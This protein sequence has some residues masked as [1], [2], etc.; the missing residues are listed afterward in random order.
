MGKKTVFDR[1]ITIILLGICIV[2]AAIVIKN[3]LTTQNTQ[4]NLPFSAV[5]QTTN[6][7]N[8]S[9]KK[10][11]PEAFVRTTTLGAELESS[12]DTIALTSSTV[13]GKL[14]ALYVTTGKEIKAGD[15]IGIVDPSTAGSV[16]KPSDIKSALSGTVYSVDSYVGA[17]ITTTTT[18]ATL[19]KTGD[20]EVVANLPER[21]LSTVTVGMKATFT[22]AAWP[23]EPFEATVKSISPAVNNSNR[24]FELI[25]SIDQAD[26]RLKEGMYVDLKLITEQ[27]DDCLIIPTSAI[28]T[29]LGENIVF[30]VEDGK[31]K[32]V[33]ITISQEDDNRSVVASGLV[34]SDQ[35]IVAGSVTH[36]SSVNIIEE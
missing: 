21:F 4:G 10:M 9:V 1:I 23:E 13:S 27:I 12:M 20:L 3:L 18:L 36:G 17:Q 6:T 2:M 16:Y 24:T 5:E 8:V 33:A 30:I 26:G 19:G 35:V 34:A 31:A 14:T 32:R 22:T 7:I 25:L 15:V 29:Y 11:Q 28:S